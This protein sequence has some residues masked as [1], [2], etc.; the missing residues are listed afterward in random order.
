MVD[1]FGAVANVGVGLMEQQAAR[2]NANRAEAANQQAL[3]LQYPAEL[4]QLRQD[5]SRGASDLLP[6][7]YGGGIGD[8][9]T[10]TNQRPGDYSF[11]PQQQQISSPYND[12]LIRGQTAQNSQSQGFN[13]SPQPSQENRQLTDDYRQQ[14]ITALQQNNTRQQNDPNGFQ[15]DRTGNIMRLIQQLNT[16][17]VS[18][19]ADFSQT[20]NGQQGI[21]NQLNQAGQVYA[22]P[23]INQV[24]NQQAGYYGQAQGLEQ[25]NIANL[26]QRL[27][28]IN[29]QSQGDIASLLRQTQQNNSQLGGGFDQNQGLTSNLL[30]IGQGIAGGQQDTS[31]FDPFIQN[32]GGALSNNQ[33]NINGIDQQTQALIDAST[34]QSQFEEDKAIQDLNDQLAARGLSNSQA[35]LEAITAAKS[36][37]SRQRSGD[38]AKL[39]QDALNNSF[40]QRLQGNSLQGQLAGQGGQLLSQQGQ[41]GNADL[42]ARLRGLETTSGLN[43][44][45]LNNLLA[46][47]GANQQGINQLGGLQNQANQQNA[48]FANTQ[49][50][51]NQQ[52]IQNPQI[53]GQQL[54]QLLQGNENRNS[55]IQQQGFANR[56][57]F[58]D[59]LIGITNSGFSAG[60]QGALQSGAI[61]AQR[62]QDNF[63]LSNSNRQASGQAFG[64]ALSFAN[65]AFNN[66]QYQNTQKSPASANNSSNGFGLTNSYPQQQAG[67]YYDNEPF[68]PGY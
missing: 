66:P 16:E 28:G 49:Y 18:S 11:S 50:G 67:G 12:K 19:P 57:A 8:Y 25:Q 55:Q 42:N 24:V 23:T 27:G 63:N 30:G 1:A 40:Q 10:F 36:Q 41:L 46:L 58:A 37:F 5:Y 48:S 47:Y 4:Q 38:I 34:A 2:R 9:G 61:Q 20:P 21:L 52:A 29:Q 35:G 17:P 31:G 68:N 15:V 7:L 65:N 53:Y 22:D 13:T 44:Q 32:V 39:R 62:G 54:L 51:L 45:G 59:R 43:N 33:S 3:R 26:L 60:Q 14:L 56:G 64:N 6:Y